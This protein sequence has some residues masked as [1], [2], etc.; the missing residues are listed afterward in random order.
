M[1]YRRKAR[2]LIDQSEGH[3]V[4]TVL[5]NIFIVLQVEGSNLSERVILCIKMQPASP[6]VNASMGL[7]KLY[8][9]HR[10]Q[11]N[12][13]E[14]LYDLKA[15]KR[16]ILE[17]R[18]QRE[19]ILLWI[20]MYSFMNGFHVTCFPSV[21]SRFHFLIQMSLRTSVASYLLTAFPIRSG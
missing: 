13:L 20:P 9:P 10:K 14:S 19:R 8:F 1:T 2:I 5:N 17:L 21:R 6:S 11:H 16:E 4:L 12:M 7:W 15:P 18:L 3:L